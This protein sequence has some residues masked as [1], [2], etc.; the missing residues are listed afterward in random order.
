M[1]EGEGEEENIMKNPQNP[2][3]PLFKSLWV[4]GKE[5]PFPKYKEGRRRGVNNSKTD[6][7]YDFEDDD[8]DDDG[9]DDEGP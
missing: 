1:G 4:G 9:D 8:E 7:E 6:V 2:K 5:I 3:Y